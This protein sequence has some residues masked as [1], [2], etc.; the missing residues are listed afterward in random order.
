[1]PP[2]SDCHDMNVS[3][4]HHIDAGAVSTVPGL[5]PTSLEVRDPGAAQGRRQHGSG[6][7]PSRAARGAHHSTTGTEEN[8]AQRDAFE[9]AAEVALPKHPRSFAREGAALS[10]AAT[11][12]ASDGGNHQTC[13]LGRQMLGG[14][15]I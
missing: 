5:A 15:W 14:L 8:V 12:S 9:D 6:L 2:S 10:G 1:M 3:P 7:R 11:C 4:V 13:R